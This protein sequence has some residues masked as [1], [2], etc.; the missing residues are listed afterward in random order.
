VTRHHCNSTQMGDDTCHVACVNACLCCCCLQAGNSMVQVHAPASHRLAMSVHM[1][2]LVLAN[3][4]VWPATQSRCGQQHNTAACR[5]NCWVVSVQ[6][7]MAHGHVCTFPAACLGCTCCSC[8]CRTCRTCNICLP[9]SE[10][11]L[12]VLQLT[13]LLPPSYCCC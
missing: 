9:H 3:D 5:A 7:S 2:L 11:L 1:L 6:H 12:V 13:P 4:R 10:S 8:C